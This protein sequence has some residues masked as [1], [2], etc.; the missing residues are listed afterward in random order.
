M[1]YGRLQFRTLNHDGDGGT[2][3]KDDFQIG[4]K[5]EEVDGTKLWSQIV[6][7]GLLFKGGAKIPEIVAKTRFPTIAVRSSRTFS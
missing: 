4:Q 1:N 7:D 6:T 5:K 3:T 2:A